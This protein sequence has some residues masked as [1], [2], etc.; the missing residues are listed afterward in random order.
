MARGTALGD[1]DPD[2]TSACTLPCGQEGARCVLLGKRALLIAER[3][4]DQDRLSVTLRLLGLDVC[5]LAASRRGAAALTARIDLVV[6]ASLAEFRGAGDLVS[7]LR[8]ERP[9][10]PLIAATPGG[11]GVLVDL[12]RAVDAPGRGAGEL[13]TLVVRAACRVARHSR[14]DKEPA[15]VLGAPPP[16]G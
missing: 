11:Q 15:A 3:P 7:L 13:A 14:I 16:A 6:C 9:W 2:V 12:D 8:D 10:V 4:E 5:H 1:E